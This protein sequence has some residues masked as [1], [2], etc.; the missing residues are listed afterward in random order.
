MGSGV[1]TER[2]VHGSRG[3]EAG[4]RSFGLLDAVHKRAE[5]GS[6]LPLRDGLKA[7]I[8]RNLQGQQP[9]LQRPASG[10]AMP[11]LS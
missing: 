10:Y 7:G 8:R 9:F 1:L 11:M 5:H 4:R 3:Q 2:K 6:P